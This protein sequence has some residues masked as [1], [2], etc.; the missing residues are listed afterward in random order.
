MPRDRF[1]TTAMDTPSTTEI[2]SP[3]K[4]TL[5]VGHMYPR[6]GRRPLTGSHSG[7]NP[8]VITSCGYGSALRRCAA[9]SNRN[10]LYRYQTAMKT[11]KVIS[12]GRMLR[13]W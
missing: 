10:Q 12:G 7:K 5:A 2:V 13:R 9:T 6:I 4:V 3:I 8:S 1:I 11:A